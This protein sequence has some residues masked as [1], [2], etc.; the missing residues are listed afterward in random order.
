MKDLLSTLLA[1]VL[2][3]GNKV[4]WKKVI[5]IVCILAMGAMFLSCAPTKSKVVYHGNVVRQDT[6]KYETVWNKKKVKVINVD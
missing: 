3:E 2:M 4:S 6:L 1:W 5:I